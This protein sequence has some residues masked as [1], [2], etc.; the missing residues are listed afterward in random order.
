VFAHVT[1]TRQTRADV[2]RA[3]RKL[4]L[5]LRACRETQR[6]LALRES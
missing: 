2:E 5:P 1:R 3:R 4:L 6:A